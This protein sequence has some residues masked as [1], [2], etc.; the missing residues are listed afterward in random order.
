MSEWKVG[1]TLSGNSKSIAENVSPHPDGSAEGVTLRGGLGVKPPNFF[2]PSL[3]G[4][5]GRLLK[6]R[7]L[8]GWSKGPGQGPVPRQNRERPPG[9]IN[10][11]KL[12][13]RANGQQP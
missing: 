7:G 3:D 5:E 6:G 1:L 11:W 10:D 2:S 8:G 12:V 13:C 9:K 4:L